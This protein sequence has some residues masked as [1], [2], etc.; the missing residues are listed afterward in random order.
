VTPVG[1]FGTVAGVTALDAA[2]AAP[3]PA[4]FDAETLNVYD[5]PFARPVTVVDV[6]GGVPLTVVGVCANVPTNGVTV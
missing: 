2:D 3:A 5:V 1:V 4:M 6:A